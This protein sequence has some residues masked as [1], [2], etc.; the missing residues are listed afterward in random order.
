MGYKV[1]KSKGEVKIFNF[2]KKIVMA[3]KKNN[4]GDRNSGYWNSGYG[5]SCDRS[6]GIFCNKNP[7]VYLFNKPT[8]L[9]WEDIDHPDLSDMQLT[10]WIP[11][12]EMTTQE[13][14]DNSTFKTTGGYLKEY[15][16]NEAWAN[17]WEKTDKKN[18]DK[19]L[20]LPNFDAEIFKD[21]TGIDVKEG[22]DCSGK[23]V[24]IDGKKYRLNLVD[25]N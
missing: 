6:S 9:D 15:E 25:D 18:K 5:N 14:K 16:Y 2:I 23:V 7:K 21:I 8:G 22:N 20:N 3:D 24:E 1:I 13:K 12:S 19:I 17:F 4:S 11:E 10:E